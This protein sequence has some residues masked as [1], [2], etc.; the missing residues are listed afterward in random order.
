M[1][2]GNGLIL[3]LS[4]FIGS[5]Y[6]LISVNGVIRNLEKFI[7]TSENN[8]FEMIVDSLNIYFWAAFV[9]KYLLNNTQIN[10]PTCKIIGLLVFVDFIIY[11]FKITKHTSLKR[12]LPYLISIIIISIPYIIA[13]YN[14]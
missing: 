6:A 11:S 8:I 7:F 1:V 3:T 14:M 13:I 4:G 10:Y 9:C 5:L 2:L 12:S